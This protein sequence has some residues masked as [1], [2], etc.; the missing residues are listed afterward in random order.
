MR[1][2]TSIMA[3][4][5]SLYCIACVLYVYSA[6]GD[7]EVTLMTKATVYC[8][9]LVVWQPPTIYKSSCTIDV[10]YFPY[11]VQTCVLKLGSWTYDGFKVNHHAHHLTHWP[12]LISLQNRFVCFIRRPIW[13]ARIA[14][15]PLLLDISRLSTALRTGK[16]HQIGI[17][18]IRRW[19]LKPVRFRFVPRR[20]PVC[21][22]YG[23]N[24]RFF[25]FL[26]SCD[27]RKFQK[28]IEPN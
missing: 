1:G 14:Q 23:V 15:I 28:I 27:L 13:F 21:V 9:G 12:R 10:E 3:F 7:Y 20:L 8:T 2:T 16:S 5:F 18:D 25:P 17:F 19:L 4:S 6:D 24:S 22:V 26:R 11:D